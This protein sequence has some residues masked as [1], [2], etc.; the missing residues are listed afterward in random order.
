MATSPFHSWG[1]VRPAEALALR[2]DWRD[3]PLPPAPPGR[4]LLPYG[5]GRSYGDSCLNDGGAMLQTRGLDRFIAF[6]PST[7]VLRAEAGTSL[8]EILRLVVPRGWFLPVTPGTRFVTLGGAI[9]NDVHG[10]NHHRAGTLGRHVRAFELLRSDGARLECTPATNADYFGATIG[11]LGLTG[12]VTWAE[13]QLRPVASARIEQESIK[14]GSLDEFFA[15]NAESEARFEYTVAWVDTRQGGRDLGRGLYLRGDH[16][17]ASA[18]P[19]DEPRGRPLLTLPFTAPSFLLNRLT[20]GLLGAAYYHRQ[21]GR[22]A[23][24]RVGLDPF[25]YPLDGIGRWNR[26]YGPRGFFQY[27]CVVPPPDAPTVARELLE[28]IA[29]SGER[30]FVNV[31]KTFGELPSPGWLSF[32]RP[33]LTFAFDFPNRGAPTLTLF[34]RL[35]AI[36]DAAGGALYPAKDARQPPALFQRAYPAWERLA[37]YVDPRFS[38]DFWRRVTGAGPRLE[39]SA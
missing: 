37:G 18:G 1:G 28:A 39:R 4:T 34:E 36:V 13:L 31:A 25:F 38:S 32:P 2:Q 19:L 3:S 12:L 21:L 14:F 29:A 8:D 15:L 7:G 11:G 20:L 6:D 23:R 17:P 22:L 26:A 16:A 24:A 27:Q 9:A 5:L 10:K 30:S 35:D 33:G